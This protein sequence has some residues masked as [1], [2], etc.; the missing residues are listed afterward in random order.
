MDR[1][2]SIL[3]G[4]GPEGRG[5]ARR[6]AQAGWEVIL[7]SRDATRAE[8]TAQEVSALAGPAARIRGAEN[9]A[10][11]ASSEVVVLAVP[12]EG[13]V[14]ILKRVASS[15]RPDAVLVS[16]VV[17]LAAAV[18]DRASRLLGVWQ[19]SAAELAA[20]LVPAG[21]S[22]VGA[23][24]NISASVLDGTVDVDCDVL[25]CSDV[26]KAREAA[27]ALAAAIPGCRPVH[28]GTLAHSRIVEALTALLIG[29][30]IRHKVHGAGVR[31]TGLP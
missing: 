16:T 11:A 14:A 28:A 2:V 23:F 10:A 20:E 5:L 27:F 24:H 30:N 7:G 15:F 8:R 13:E 4:T 29:I 18:G 19:G 26:A 6:W 22:V 12:F 1:T 31:I 25:V 21:V 3:G 17:P 9:A